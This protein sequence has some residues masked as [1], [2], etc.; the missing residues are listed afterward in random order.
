[1]RPFVKQISFQI[2][3]KV[4]FYETS[5]S[6]ASCHTMLTIDILVSMGPII[7]Q[8]TYA[9]G[10]SGNSGASGGSGGFGTPPFPAVAAVAVASTAAWAASILVQM[11]W[12][13]DVDMSWSLSQPA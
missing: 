11:K 3:K 5:S 4:R 6:I 12:N 13:T 8:K 10:T 1:M 9:A 2:G 7:Q